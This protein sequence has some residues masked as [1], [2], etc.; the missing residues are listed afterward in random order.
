MEMQTTKQK[1]CICHNAFAPFSKPWWQFSIVAFVVQ[2]KLSLNPPVH[3]S[4]HLIK[5]A[6]FLHRSK[7][8][9]MHLVRLHPNEKYCINLIKLKLYI[10][11]V[12]LFLKHLDQRQPFL[13]TTQFS[14]WGSMTY[15]KKKLQNKF[16]INDMFLQWG[17][18]EKLN[19]S[20]IMPK[21]TVYFQLLNPFLFRLWLPYHVIVTHVFDLCLEFK[22][23]D[24]NFWLA[25]YWTTR[26][27][28][29]FSRIQ[30]LRFKF[31]HPF[32]R[33][34]EAVIM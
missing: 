11:L 21:P 7:G 24:L 23:V 20:E 15:E 3:R 8:L 26:F 19:P 29:Y 27:C 6:L 2:V 13:C 9:L 4:R 34:F 30:G 16:K 14:F 22:R 12:R 10:F 1:I 18:L 31:L 25:S 32:L 33:L 28:L 17:D 5:F